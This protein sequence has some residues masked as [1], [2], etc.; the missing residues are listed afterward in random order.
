MKTQVIEFEAIDDQ[1]LQAASVGNLHPDGLRGMGALPLRCADLERTV[2]LLL[3]PP[4]F[5]GINFS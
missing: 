5:A 4:E 2:C 3:G 1:K